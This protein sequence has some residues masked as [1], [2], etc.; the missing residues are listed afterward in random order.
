MARMTT[1]TLEAQSPKLDVEDPVNQKMKQ[2]NK[3]LACSQHGGAFCIVPDAEMMSLLTRYNVPN[4]H[5]RTTCHS[6]EE[7]DDDTSTEASKPVWGVHDLPWR[8]RALTQLLHFLDCLKILQQRTIP[9]SSNKRNIGSLEPTCHIH[10]DKPS[11]RTIPPGR[12][13]SAYTDE[14]ITEAVNQ[15]MLE[16]FAVGP[17]W[18]HELPSS[19]FYEERAGDVESLLG[20]LWKKH[21]SECSHCR[22]A[23]TDGS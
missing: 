22:D 9:F 1:L 6:D 23:D 12:S 11:S 21:K 14:F 3:E 15:G 2:L 4:T 17:K 19:E 18:C 8:N 13:R 7:T 5:I 16:A 10:L 20:A